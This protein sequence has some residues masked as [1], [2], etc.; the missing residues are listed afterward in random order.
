MIEFL[1]DHYFW[2]YNFGKFPIFNKPVDKLYSD[3]QIIVKFSY[4]LFLVLIL[5]N[6][7]NIRELESAERINPLWPLEVFKGVSSV[8]LALYFKLSLLLSFVLLC[9][10]NNN[11]FLKIF[12]FIN[13][14]LFVAFTNSFGK[15]NHGLY[16][17]LMYLFGIIFMPNSNKAHYKEKTILMFASMQFFLLLTYSLTGF[18]K[19][20]WGV[21]ECFNGQVSL[22]SPLSMR[23]VI[24]LQNQL[25]EPT[26]VGSWLVENYWIAWF[27]YLGAV[28]IELFSI[29]IFFRANL[30]KIWG[31][32]LLFLHAG[33]ALAL[34]VSMYGAII[35]IGL[36]LIMSPFN[37]RTNFRK[38]ITSLPIIHELIK[39]AHSKSK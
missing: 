19:V 12:A 18:W 13:F 3:I 26:V 32:L 1:K 15:I 10:K 20:F 33:I 21:I 2:K 35:C 28:Y 14:F 34:D 6:V 29:L 24:I 16:L 5:D 39:L 37:Y 11:L 9:F 25:I 36:F 7:F 31:V 4:V 22:F 17:P 8:Y 30:H 27:L 23:N 38:T